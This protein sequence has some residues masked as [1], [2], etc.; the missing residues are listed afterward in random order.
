MCEPSRRFAWTTFSRSVSSSSKQWLARQRRDP[1]VKEAKRLD[2]RSRAAFK[3][4][5]L[6]Q[7]HRLLK[8]GGRVVD[9]GAAPGGW[10]VVAAAEVGSSGGAVMAVDLLDMVP[11]AGVTF[12]RA[13][14]TAPETQRRVREWLG[15]RAADCVLSDMAPCFSGDASTDHL[16]TL[17][18]CAEGLRFAADVLVPGGTFLGKF[19]K[20]R[21]EKEL[22]EAARGGFAKVRTV[23]PKASRGNSAE[24]YLLATGFK[25]PG[26]SAETAGAGMAT[27]AGTARMGG[28]K[29]VAFMPAAGAGSV[30][31]RDSSKSGEICVEGGGGKAF[32]PR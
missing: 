1:Y 15:G 29:G 20:G 8:P 27:V 16:R 12:I 32:A 23:K 10:S 30:A 6:Q 13:D 4:R 17:A 11:V 3:L 21:D 19:L 2:T 5:E 28:T 9:L 25:G 7:R 18:L 22:L 26:S 24:S 14:F 31:G